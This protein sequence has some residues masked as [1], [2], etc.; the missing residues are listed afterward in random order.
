MINIDGR[1]L[2][3]ILFYC[4]VLMQKF[5][6]LF[7]FIVFLAVEATLSS[8]LFWWHHPMW[9]EDHFP[10]CCARCL[11]IHHKGCKISCFMWTNSCFFIAYLLIFALINQHCGFW[12]MVFRCCLMSSLLTPFEHIWFCK[13]LHLMG[14]PWQLWFKRRVTFIDQY[15]VDIFFLLTIKVFECLH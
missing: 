2:T 7:F 6:K 3:S 13:Q 9:G 12:W 1:L 8:I 4:F 15:I 10:W 5:S 11:C 14:L